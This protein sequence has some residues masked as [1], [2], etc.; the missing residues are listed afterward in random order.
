MN[1]KERKE[2]EALVISLE[3]RLDTTNYNELERKLSMIYDDKP[4][5]I[6]MDCSQL[7]YISSSG[8]RVMLMFLKR[9]K[10]AGVKFVLCSLQDPIREI[11]DISGFTGIFEIFATCDE[12]L[13]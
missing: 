7:Q 13:K 12:A 9:S 8:L 2:K 11:F 1:I 6:L 10:T 3:G 5:N 4:V